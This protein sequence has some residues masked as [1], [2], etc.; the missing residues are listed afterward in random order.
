[1]EP[2]EPAEELVGELD[3]APLEAGADGAGRD[4]EENAPPL[5]GIP[6]GTLPGVRGK[7]EGVTAEGPPT[8]GAGREEKPEGIE[9]PGL[10]EMPAGDGFGGTERWMVGAG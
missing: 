8:E 3:D 5:W 7:G 10:E 6:D 2:P 1:M 9:P 4:G